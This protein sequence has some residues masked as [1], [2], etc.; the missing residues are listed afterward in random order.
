MEKYPTKCPMLGDK[1]HDTK[2]LFA[3]PQNYKCGG[4]AKCEAC[5]HFISAHIERMEMEVD[6]PPDLFRALR[7][8]CPDFIKTVTQ[9]SVA[10]EKRSMIVHQDAF[11][12]LDADVLMLLGSAVKFAGVL[13]VELRF[14]GKNGETVKKT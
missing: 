1:D 9:L 2:C 6:F 7:D 4:C 11:P 10:E 5:L 13:G 3:L 14:I 8:R 12:S